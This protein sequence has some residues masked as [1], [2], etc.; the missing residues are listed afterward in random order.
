MFDSTPITFHSNLYLTTASHLFIS[1]SIIS[2]F[3]MLADVY[4]L[5]SLQKDKGKY[6]LLPEGTDVDT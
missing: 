5:L 2:E 4:I 1:V 6:T 3:A